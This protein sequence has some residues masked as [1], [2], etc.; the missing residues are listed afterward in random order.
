MNTGTNN[1]LQLRKNIERGSRGYRWA[2]ALPGLLSWCILALIMLIAF[3]NTAFFAAMV[4]AFMA[5][6]LV[7]CAMILFSALKGWSQIEETRGTDWQAR[8]EA[9]FPGWRDYYYCTIIP[10]A[11]ESINVLRPTIESLASS[12]FPADRKFL[13]LAPEAALPKGR[14][15]AEALAAEFEGRFA[16]IY[17][18]EHVLKPG[19]LKGKASNENSCGRFAYEKLVE[20]GI[21]PGRVLVSSN[22]SDMHIEP[23]YPAY[24]LHS[25]LSEGADRDNCIY[26]PIPTDLG[27]YW[28][29]SFFTRVLIMGGLVWRITLQVHGGKRCTV[30]AFYSMSLRTLH[31]IGFWDSDVIPEDERTMFKAI[32]RF[33]ASFRVKPLMVMTRGSS[34]RGDGFW[35]SL[36]EQYTQILRWAWGAS[37]IAHS[38]SVYSGLGLK[39]RKAMRG[40]IINQIRVATEWS[41]APF[42]LVFGGFL[43]SLTNPW[44]AYTSFGQVYSVAMTA[45]AI[46]STF[47][48]LCTIWLEHLMA[49]PKP[50]KGNGFI[51]LFRLAEWFLTPVVSIAFGSLP[52][53]E[54]QTRLIMNQRIA[55]VESRKE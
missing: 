5:Y 53:L 52:A 49:P 55:Y 30:F 37:E 40:P 17:I 46:A 9:D 47:F 45:I 11:S 31:E 36:S 7:N 15:I 24:L 10:F 21:D 48:L 1:N 4:L 27:D 51:S 16:G 43:P 2:E 44:F 29:A 18:S 22:D 19:E 13:F 42:I 32:E 41:L 20:L 50:E 14:A 28:G 26:Q 3:R 6:W 8:L 38:F 34:I 35:G 12:D 23:H 33:G 25:Y 54:A 39:Q